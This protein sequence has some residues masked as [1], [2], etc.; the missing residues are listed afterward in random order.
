MYFFY[1]AVGD[2]G[3]PACRAFIMGRIEWLCAG[4]GGMRKEGGDVMGIVIQDVL[5]HPP[6][7][8]QAEP[9]SGMSRD[10]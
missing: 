7:T 1:R 4:V 8:K 5:T 3:G 9:S 10:E 2:A 6:A